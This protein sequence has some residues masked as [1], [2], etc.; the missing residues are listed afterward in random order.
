MAFFK[1]PT[2]VV[3]SDTIG[4]GTKIWHFAHVRAGAPE[5]RFCL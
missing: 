3:E 2:A 1:H 5:F 4:D